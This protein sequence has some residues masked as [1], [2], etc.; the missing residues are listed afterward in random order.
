MITISGKWYDG[1]TSKQVP[2]QCHLYDNGHV[3]V[4]RMADNASLLSLVQ[5]EVKVSPRLADTPRYLY[6]PGCEKFET[7]DNDSVDRALAVYKRPAQLGLIHLLESR[8]GYVL[9]SLV[10]MLL[11]IFGSIKYGIPFTAKTI[12][13]RLPPAILE[14]AGRQTLNFFDKTVLAPSKLDANRQQRLQQRFQAV[15]K[16]HTG[17]DL[18]I[19]FRKGDRIGPNAFALPSGIIVFTDEMVELAQHDDELVAV[20][21]HE[22]GHVIHRHGLRTL[23][24]DSLLGFILLAITGDIAGSSELFLGLP[25]LLTELA[26][27]RAFEREADQYALNY[28]KTQQIPLKHFAALMRRIDDEMAQKGQTKDGKWANYLSS[29]PLTQERLQQFDEKSN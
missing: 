9:V 2:A 15:L 11:I 26:Y 14:R 3:Q 10:A 28:L 7:I 24:Q 13:Y 18:S 12:A 22:I 20:L 8:W 29:H 27:S 21:A 6:F 1:Q 4:K 5:F 23:I 16:N 19:L 25:V 17:T